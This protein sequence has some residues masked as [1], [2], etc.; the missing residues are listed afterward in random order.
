VTLSVISKPFGES[1]DFE[2]DGLLPCCVW[3][4]YIRALFC[5]D[6]K[7][8]V[9]SGLSYGFALRPCPASK[10]VQFIAELKAVLCANAIAGR[11]SFMFLYCESSH[12]VRQQFRCCINLSTTA[13]DLGLCDPVVICS[14]PRYRLIAA[15]TPLTNSGAS[16][17]RKESRTPFCKTKPAR[18]ALANIL[19][20]SI[21]QKP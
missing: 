15:T 21:G 5:G 8:R 9:G 16:S 17:L 6:L 18:S 7:A 14:M 20:F 4:L 12:F 1:T 11:K 19:L 2:E 10:G 3:L 13:L